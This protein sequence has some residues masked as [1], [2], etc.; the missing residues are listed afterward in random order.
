MTPPC[1]IPV[2]AISAN[3]LAETMTQGQLSSFHGHLTKPI[4]IGALVGAIQEA[5]SPAQAGDVAYGLSRVS[6]TAC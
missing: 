3:V 6:Q 2:I 4:S 5:T 1:Q